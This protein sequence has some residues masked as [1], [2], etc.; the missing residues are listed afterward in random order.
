MVPTAS[1][2]KTQTVPLT[3]SGCFDPRCCGSIRCYAPKGFFL[4]PEGCYATGLLPTYQLLAATQ[5]FVPR[6]HFLKD[7]CFACCKI[8]V[9][10]PRSTTVHQHWTCT[11]EGWYPQEQT[12]LTTKYRQ[13]TPLCWLHII[14]VEYLPRKPSTNVWRC[15]WKSEKS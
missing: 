9:S 2:A 15:Q 14:P 8:V 6:I 3:P 7:V 5:N 4:S 1:V 12:V 11:N 13:S 10:W